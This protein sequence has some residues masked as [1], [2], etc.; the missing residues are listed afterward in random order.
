MDESAQGSP[1]SRKK[2]GSKLGKLAHRLGIGG[3][4]KR[5]GSESPRH[6]TGSPSLEERQVTVQPVTGYQTGYQELSPVAGY[7]QGDVAP[8]TGPDTPGGDLGPYS[9]P[10][11]AGSDSPVPSSEEKPHHQPLSEVKERLA[12]MKEAIQRQAGGA[13]GAESPAGGATAGER[14][15]EEVPG[16]VTEGFYQRPVATGKGGE[17]DGAGLE[18]GRQAQLEVLGGAVPV[19]P[20]G[21]AVPAAPASPL[22]PHYG[23]EDLDQIPSPAQY[24]QDPAHLAATQSA[25]PAL[26][27]AYVPRVKAERVGGFPGGT[28]AAG[29]EG[30]AGQGLSQGTGA[31]GEAPLAGGMGNQGPEAAVTPDT[32]TLHKEEQAYGVAINDGPESGK[33]ETLSGPEPEQMPEKEIVGEVLPEHEEYDRAGPRREPVLPAGPFATQQEASVFRPA[34]A[35]VVGGADLP[36]AVDREL[37]ATLQPEELEQTVEQVEAVLPVPLEQLKQEHELPPAPEIVDEPPTDA[38]PSREPVLP[39]GPFAGQQEL[40]VFGGPTQGARLPIQVDHE[41]EAAIATTE[42][43]RNLAQSPGTEEAQEVEERIIARAH[44]PGP[45]GAEAKRPRVSASRVEEQQ[46]W[47]FPQADAPAAEIP[48]PVDLPAETGLSM[49]SSLEVLEGQRR[50]WP[51]N[52][53]E[54]LL[55]ER[56][57]A[58]KAEEDGHGQEPAGR[59]EEGEGS[60]ASR[61]EDRGMSAAEEQPEVVAADTRLTPGEQGDVV[62]AAASAQ[63]EQDMPRLVMQPMQLDVLPVAAAGT[64]REEEEE[65]EGAA[66]GGGDEVIAK[67][68]RESHP[69]LKEALMSTPEADDSLL[70]QQE[71]AP[72]LSIPA[73][74]GASAEAEDWSQAAPMMA[75]AGGPQQEGAAAAAEGAEPAEVGASSGVVSAAKEGLSSAMGAVGVAAGAVGAAVSAAVVTVERVVSSAVAPAREAGEEVEGAAEEAA[76]ETKGTA[77]RGLAQGRDVAERAAVGAAESA[78]DAAQGAA[79]YAGAAAERTKEAAGGAVEEVKGAAEGATESATTSARGAGEAIAGGAGAL[80]GA[81][82]GAAQYAKAAAEGVAEGAADAA[83]GDIS[84]PG[85]GASEDEGLGEV[86]LPGGLALAPSSA[87]V[88][89]EAAEKEEGETAGEQLEHLVH[90]FEHYVKEEPQEGSLE[91]QGSSGDDTFP[92]TRRTAQQAQQVSASPSVGGLQEP[93]PSPISGAVAS[94]ANKLDLPS[95]SDLGFSSSQ[96]VKRTALSG[97]GWVR[98][99]PFLTAAVA[100]ASYPIVVVVAV[101]AEF[102]PGL[103]LSGIAAL[104]VAALGLLLSSGAAAV[105]PG[106]VPESEMEM[107]ED[108]A[109]AAAGVPGARGG[110]AAAAR[111]AEDV[112]TPRAADAAAGGALAPSGP[113]ASQWVEEE[114][115]E[116]GDSAGQGQGPGGAVKTHGLLYGGDHDTVAGVYEQEL[117]EALEGGGGS[118]G[119]GGRPEDLQSAV[120]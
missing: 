7:G 33:L 80:A 53:A 78:E 77:E 16:A 99:H 62:D 87:E 86:A 120:L 59:G 98:A 9:G 18:A 65:E 37:E 26:T 82:V 31:A 111:A 5:G 4:S 36:V 108:Q 1:R 14:L 28:L 76:A 54:M 24:S 101:L 103:L 71:A 107:L 84:A 64:R 46:P 105:S 34:V 106:V 116:E 6:R 50:E 89:A 41:L 40:S 8:A 58:Q 47:G 115:E 55:A 35:T 73:Q 27:E 67:E 91:G 60:A 88:A 10:E 17:Y 12:R 39:A 68:E 104:L 74:Q 2:F 83:S 13:E 102:A 61:Q 23:G 113:Q 69:T 42:E 52:E 43:V 118:A 63:A 48:L 21:A 94:F 70:I 19:T 112:P 66:G 44:P 15:H 92:P 85:G 25:A 81:A 3:H 96:G 11:S 117:V 93:P 29:A 75:T 45:T 72:G 38:G 20:S 119:N 95:V 79:E 110:H 97:W 90:E 30:L 57:M 51:R 100:G 56:Y 32:G 22:S 109:D 114:E 49:P